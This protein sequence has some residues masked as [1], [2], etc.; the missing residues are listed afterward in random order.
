MKN[1]SNLF[2]WDYA[3]RAADFPK[4]PYQ[5]ID[6]HCHINGAQAAALYREASTLYGVSKA[7]SMSQLEEVPSVKAVLG[8]MIE[9]IAFP[10][11]RGSDAIEDHGADYLKRIEEFRR[12]GSKIAKFWAAPRIFDFCPGD[13]TNHPMRLDSSVR[14]PTIDKAVELGMKLM[15]HIADPDVWFE[16]I[17]TDAKHYGTKA[18]Q[19]ELL[20]W[21]LES[22]KVPTIAAHMGASPED[23]RLLD[24][25]LQRHANLYLDSSAMKW[26]VRELSKHEPQ[27]RVEFFKKWSGRI[28]FGTDIVTMDA[29]IVGGGEHE[30][31]RKAQSREQAFDLYAS[32]FWA[33]RSLFETNFDGDSPVADPDDSGMHTRL[34]GIVLPE[35]ELRTLYCGAAEAFGELR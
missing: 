24:I 23:L 31:A 8:E 28:L 33:M 18:Q 1:S 3:A 32:R 10:R 7:W 29:H 2:D 34:R 11:I 17:Y 26:I 19:Y 22:Y 14:R 25:L 35:L 30:I 5:I 15:L 16:R 27:R 21:V 20:E 4:L 6:A 13:F 12:L 9:F